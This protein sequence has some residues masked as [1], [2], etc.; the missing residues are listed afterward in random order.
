MARRRLIHPTESS[1]DEDKRWWSEKYAKPRERA[2]CVISL[3][4]QLYRDAEPYRQGC[5]RWAG[6]YA[7]DP[8]LATQMSFSPRSR[9]FT[10][11]NNRPAPLALNAVKA[12]SDT[13]VAMVTADRPKVSVVTDDGDWDLQQKASN[14]EK[15]IKG[16]FNEN[17]IYRTANLV[18]YDVVRM[19]TG[20]VKISDERPKKTHIR[21]ERV[22]PTEV[23]VDPD[24]AIYG[25]PQ[26]IYQVKRVDKL[27]LQELYPKLARELDSGAGDLAVLANGSTH[28]ATGGDY[29]LVVEAWRRKTAEDMPGLHVICSGSV[30]LFEEEWDR[31][32]FPFEFLYR[33]QPSEGMWGISLGQE[34]SGLQ[35]AVNKLLRDIQ[36]AQNLVVGHYL[37]ENSTEVNTGTISDRIGGFIRY[38]G[39]A[40][41]YVAPPPVP[42]Q[43][44][45]YLQQ[46][47]QRCFETIGISQQSAQSQKPAGL[48]SGKALL[49]YADIQ[50]QRFKPSYQEYQH[51]FIRLGRQIIATAR[52]MDDTFYVK[53]AGRGVMKAVSWADTGGLEESE[54]E[55]MLEPTN[56]LADDPAARTQQVTDWMVAKLIT[57]KQ[58]RRL[59]DN[60][61]LDALNSLENAS[62]DLVMKIQHQILSGGE[63]LGPEPFMDLGT[64]AGPQGPAQP[65]EAIQLMQLGYLK[66][67]IAGCPEERLELLDRWITQAFFILQNH[68][69][70][71]VAPNVPAGQQPPGVPAPPP[72]PPGAPGPGGP[73][74]LI[75]PSA[76]PSAP[77][78]PLAPGRPPPRQVVAA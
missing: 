68:S 15:F 11:A 58:G 78:G 29:V 34:L 33:Q 3:V 47:W 66:A 43:T 70:P 27:V 4:A 52:D 61:D 7:N 38:R 6:L 28:L 75:R 13:Y 76:G 32:S 60:P 44:I 50:S 67:K 26:C 53:A 64:P 18:N 20:I 46:L 73:G 37:I 35:L 48:N 49:V 24:D 57:D 55:L 62:Y 12:V 8:Y 74:G 1:T 54:F 59:M 72:P 56:A 69:A 71:L 65:G 77:G 36:R 45:N 19:G 9:N 21:I 23:L 10:Q 40:P 63:Y 39:T 30:T 31:D 5:Y 25:D 14:L 16:V 22:S 2:Q 42:D 41:E 17:D 51:F